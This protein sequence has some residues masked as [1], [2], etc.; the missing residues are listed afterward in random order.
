[1]RNI[2]LIIGISMVLSQTYVYAQET[3]QITLKEAKEEAKKKFADD[4]YYNLDEIIRTQIKYLQKYQNEEIDF[5][6]FSDG[7]DL[8]FYIWH[9]TIAD[10]IKQHLAEIY[11]TIDKAYDQNNLTVLIEECMEIIK[12]ETDTLGN[13]NYK[14][15]IKS[16]LTNKENLLKAFGLSSIDQVKEYTDEQLF[17]IRK[18]KMQDMYRLPT[19]RW[20][21]TPTFIQRFINW[22]KGI[23]STK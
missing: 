14:N 18:E 11:Y 17:A 7:L 15:T 23:P 1:M 22:W 8:L 2:S 3:H 19:T 5:S 13:K 10:A 20:F 12:K 16:T 9:Y 6:S 21:S 4:L